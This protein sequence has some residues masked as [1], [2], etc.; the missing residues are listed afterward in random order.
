[1]QADVLLSDIIQATQVVSTLSEHSRKRTAMTSTLEQIVC[2]TLQKIEC[3]KQA[4]GANNS[5]FYTQ[6]CV[7]MKQLT[8]W[9]AALALFEASTGQI[10]KSTISWLRTYVPSR[11]WGHPVVFHCWIII[12]NPFCVLQFISLSH[13]V[14]IFFLSAFASRMSWVLFWQEPPCLHAG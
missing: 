2:Y 13:F 7:Y 3:D 1:M 14:E 9:L 8:K 10:A 6:S 5:A 12:E 11:C 4:A